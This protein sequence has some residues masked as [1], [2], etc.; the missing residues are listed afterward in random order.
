MT[1]SK[2]GFFDVSVLLEARADGT[3]T[4]NSVIDWILARDSARF[5]TDAQIRW[6]NNHAAMLYGPL[7]LEAGIATCGRDDVGR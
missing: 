2:A 6:G 1:H 4:N 3:L 5:L 7:R